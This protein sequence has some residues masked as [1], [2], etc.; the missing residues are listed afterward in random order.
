[1]HTSC[2]DGL[3][4]SQICS[5]F[6]LYRVFF[7]YHTWTIPRL[8]PLQFHLRPSPLMMLLCL[9]NIYLFKHYQSRMSSVDFQN[10]GRT[11]GDVSFSFFS[12][13]LLLPLIHCFPSCLPSRW[14]YQTWPCCASQSTTTTISWLGS[15]SCLLTACRLAT[16]T[17]L[18][19][20][21]A[22]SRCRCP[23]SSAKSSSRP[24]CPT[25][26]EVRETHKLQHLM[27]FILLDRLQCMGKTEL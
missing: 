27:Y 19:E 4:S 6:L 10:F 21:K 17:S 12:V 18:W 8:C 3:V 15:A 26:S 25:A 7:F 5:V 23:Q 20:T 14:S 24:T 16:A 9:A 11:N 13:W 22:T 1:M 2:R